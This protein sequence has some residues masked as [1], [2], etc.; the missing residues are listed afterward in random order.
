MYV[1]WWLFANKQLSHWKDEQSIYL[2]KLG[3]NC[4]REGKRGCPSLSCQSMIWSRTDVELV[5]LSPWVIIF[6][7]I[8]IEVIKTIHHFS[9]VN[10]PPE[11]RSWN[12][13]WESKKV[14]QQFKSIDNLLTDKRLQVSLGTWMTY[15][16][17]I[18]SKILIWP[19]PAIAKKLPYVI[20]T[21]S[22]PGQGDYVWNRWEKLVM[23]SFAPE[24]IR[25][26]G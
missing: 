10:R 21:F 8:I 18:S 23:W 9:T 25:Y 22:L 12:K 3:N 6:K 1:E 16:K 4:P 20:L 11:F 15:F 17:L 13:Q 19:F 5:P 26:W 2:N 7:E 14:T 24:S